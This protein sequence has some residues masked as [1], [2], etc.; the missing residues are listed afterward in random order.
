[1][2]AECWEGVAV[3]SGKLS[4]LP[5]TWFHERCIEKELWSFIP[6]YLKPILSF[7]DPINQI[8]DCVER[9]LTCGGLI[10]PLDLQYLAQAV[11]IIGGGG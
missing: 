10:E 5:F 2:L 3:G 1:M 6:D 7:L 9:G 8:V 11:N 4:V